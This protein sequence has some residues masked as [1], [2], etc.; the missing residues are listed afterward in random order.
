[1]YIPTPQNTPPVV[2]VRGYPDSLKLI[3]Y[4]ILK[5]KKMAKSVKGVIRNIND[6]VK[7]K[8]NGKQFLS[9]E[10]EFLDGA[11]KGMK[12]WANRTITNA[13]GSVKGSTVKVGQEVELYVS[14]VEDA[15][16]P[17]G[18]RAFFEVSASSVTDS[19]TINDAL[20]AMGL[21]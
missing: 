10:V 19:A 6:E 18:F 13:D 15:E 3:I 7:V 21:V 9:M 16:A 14:T 2:A 12:Y 8:T 5:Q 4:S 17:G 11:L 20:K 1:M